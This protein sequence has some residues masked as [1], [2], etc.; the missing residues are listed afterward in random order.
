MGA[1]LL[2][3]LLCS[4]A[5]ARFSFSVSADP[6]LSTI[7]TISSYSSN[8]DCWSSSSSATDMGLNCTYFQ[9]NLTFALIANR[10]V[11]E[12]FG[13]VVTQQADSS[14]A[15]G[16]SSNTVCSLTSFGPSL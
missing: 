12:T 5:V 14:F 10:S 16:T 4:V 3:S 15:V 11:S 8:S 1:L 6:V 2:L 13:H 9:Y 7:T